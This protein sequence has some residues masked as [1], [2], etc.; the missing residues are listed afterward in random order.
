MYVQSHKIGHA[1]LLM[2]SEHG[3]WMEGCIH[4]ISSHFG[5]QWVKNTNKAQVGFKTSPHLRKMSI[6]QCKTLPNRMSWKIQIWQS[7]IIYGKKE[8]TQPADNKIDHEMKIKPP[9]S[10]CM[11]LNYFRVHLI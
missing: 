10:V 2:R 4:C 6:H 7:Q 11:E 5:A 3:Q 9:L 1:L 8:N